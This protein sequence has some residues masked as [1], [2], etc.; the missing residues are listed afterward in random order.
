MK[1]Q[2]KT[3][4]DPVGNLVEK[5]VRTF[6]FKSPALLVCL[7]AGSFIF[8]EAA[9]PK[10]IYYGRNKG[11]KICAEVQA[12]ETEQREWE[13]RSIKEDAQKFRQIVYENRVRLG[14]EEAC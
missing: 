13:K 11:Q 5:G 1:L 12:M 6:V 4:N 10:S 7:L 3:N 8:M 9:M 14:L 2:T